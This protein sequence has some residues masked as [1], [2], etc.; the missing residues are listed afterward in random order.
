MSH[1]DCAL[2]PPF[3]V[4][5]SCS[6]NQ[7]DDDGDGVGDA[8]DNCPETPNG[9]DAGTC[10]RIVGDT[11]V[12]GYQ[13]GGVFIIC[14]EDADCADTGGICQMEQ[15]NYNSSGCGDV[16]E[17]EG[18]FDGDLD[19]DGMDA[20]TFKADFG[21]RDCEVGTPCNGNFDC[22]SDV[23]GSDAIMF[24][25]DFGRSDCPSCSFSCF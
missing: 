6:M 23:D 19:V 4:L 5:N 3:C 17:C 18:N 15:G 21:R 24:K 8:C 11:M 16:C 10:V 1:C 14:D 25:I 7:E 20:L 22:D 12:S 9:P 2:Q 13:V